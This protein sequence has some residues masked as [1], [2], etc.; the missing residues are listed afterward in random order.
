[1]KKNNV[2][3]CARMVRNLDR[4]KII[5]YKKKQNNSDYFEK[6]FF[7]LPFNFNYLNVEK[8]FHNY[9]KD[10]ISFSS[11][12]NNYSLKLIYNMNSN[13]SKLFIHNFPVNKPISFKY[14]ICSKRSCNYCFLA[15]TNSYIK[16]N[17]F[18]LPSMS[19]SDCKAI[20]IIYIIY[21]S[22]CLYYYIGQ[23]KNFKKRFNKHKQNILKKENVIN[24]E[25]NDGKNLVEH[26][27]LKDHCYKKHVK[28]FIYK[29]NVSDLSDR[30][31]IENQLI[32]LFLK[33]NILILN[34]KITDMYK[35]NKHVY[36]FS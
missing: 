32:H 8:F 30:L 13:L 20:N 7:K 1:M 4:D 25:I 3:K 34:E 36:L 27:N 29:T 21:C 22:K 10:S 14:T 23:T 26:F 31:N 9:N 18:Y 11:F 16:L 6:L 24:E 15:N 12:F 28:F 2:F 5:P 35:Y 19:N 17:N 33:L